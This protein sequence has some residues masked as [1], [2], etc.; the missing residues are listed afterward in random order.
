MTPSFRISG[1][2]CIPLRSEPRESSEMVSSILFGESF[3]LLENTI[4]NNG[5]VWHKVRCT[6]DDYVGWIS[7]EVYELSFLSPEPKYLVRK[8]F[9]IEK[10]E[11]QG[12]W[13]SP[14][15]YWFDEG[16]AGDEMDELDFA[17]EFMKV[18]YLWGGRSIFGIDCSGLT[19]V[20]MR[21]K[22]E[23][24][25]PRD[26]SEQISRGIQISWGKHQTGDLAFFESEHG[27]INHVGIIMRKDSILH[28]SGEVKMEKITAAGIESNKT[29]EL[30]HLLHSIRRIK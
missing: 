21:F 30:T 6:H 15:A 8:S 19:Q 14:G 4:N 20:Y 18:P 11:F 5:S 26:A 23:P 13:L 9:K 2:S 17:R 28:A 1:T 27:R 29:H 24:T 7:N 22:G 25:F 12:L 3:E 10:G 16:V